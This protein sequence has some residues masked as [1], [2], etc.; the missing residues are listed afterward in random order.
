MNH[1]DYLLRP[2][3]LDDLDTI[4]R[5]SQA[6][7]FGIH[8]LK[9]GRARL[10]ER[11]ERS[12]KAF[13]GNEPVRGDEI[14]HFVL[15]DLRENRIV[16]TS[17][18]VTSA[19]VNG[20]FYCYRNEFSV[21]ASDELGIS[22]REHTLRLCEDLSGHTLLSSFYIEPEYGN[23]LAP[24]L[25]SRGR[26]MFIRNFPHLFAQRIGAENPG[27]CDEAG[28]SPF[29]NALGGR[30]LKMPFPEA[31]QRTRGRSKSF[32]A[33]LM[34]RSPIYVSLLAEDAQWAMGQLHP[35]GEVPFEILV[36]EG[37]DVDS[38]IDIFDGGPIA[39]ARVAMLNTVVSAIDVDLRT[40]PLMAGETC[41]VANMERSGFCATLAFGEFIEN[42]FLQIP[43]DAIER[44]GLRAGLRACAVR[45]K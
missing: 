19:G 13:A 16:G 24:Q 4:E 40:A 25:L 1:M 37:F 14:Y 12:L 7:T 27:L 32:I 2:A 36:S 9:P 30:F 29:W 20:R 6:S 31:E 3:N 23:S 17:G 41:L 8:T 15:E 26:L 28:N 21:H 33:E 5:F 45:I 11:L 42:N 10:A 43:N 38:F 18:I 22:N 39:E 34:P 35:D 44:L